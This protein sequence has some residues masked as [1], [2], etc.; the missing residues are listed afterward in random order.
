MRVLGSSSIV[1]GPYDFMSIW[2]ILLSSFMCRCSHY[3]HF[4]SQACV[5]CHSK[6]CALSTSLEKYILMA[7]PAGDYQGPDNFHMTELPGA[8]PRQK[9]YPPIT[10]RII[11]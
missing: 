4:S 8:S 2:T 10:G 1:Y 6:T 7:A 3:I 9:K 5:S 11:I